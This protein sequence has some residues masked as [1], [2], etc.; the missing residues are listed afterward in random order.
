MLSRILKHLIEKRF[1]LETETGTYRDKSIKNEIYTMSGWC[2]VRCFKILFE[3]RVVPGN[4]TPPFTDKLFVSC[5]IKHYIW[6]LNKYLSNPLSCFWSCSSGAIPSK[7][8]S[9]YQQI[10][11]I[12]RTTS[13]FEYR[14]Y[15]NTNL[16]ADYFKY[17]L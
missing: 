12:V 3:W 13:Y 8:D 6:T 5:L 9:W 7:L 16:K 17:H 2:D 4:K 1:I 10:I 11:K 14:P 15:K